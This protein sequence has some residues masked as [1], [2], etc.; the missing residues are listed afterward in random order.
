MIV[1]AD[2][3]AAHGE[4]SRVVETGGYAEVR[5]VAD[6]GGIRVLAVYEHGADTGGEA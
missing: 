1:A 5:Y 2:A 4:A 6:G 3:E